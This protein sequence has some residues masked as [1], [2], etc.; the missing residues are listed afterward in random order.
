MGLVRRP[1]ADPRD[2]PPACLARYAEVVSFYHQAKRWGFGD[3]M[4]KEGLE[5]I[6]PRASDALDLLDAEIQNEADR[7]AGERARVKVTAA[8]RAAAK[9]RG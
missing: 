6:D 8:E 9:P 2:R 5:E 4:R 7:L 1:P 3:A